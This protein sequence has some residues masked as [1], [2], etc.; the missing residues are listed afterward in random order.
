VTRRPRAATSTASVTWRDG[1]HLT[2]TPIWCDARRRRDVCFVSSA[3]RVGR[4]GH[5]QLIG[6][7]LTLALLGAT[8]GGHLAVPLHRRFTLGTLRL[9]LIDPARGPGASALFVDG[10]GQ[11]F[12][13]AGAIRAGAEVRACDALVVGAPYGKR[14]HAFPPLAQTIERV[15]AWAK[16]EL[17]GGRRPVLLVDTAL[18]GLEVA[19]HL[20][21][22]GIPLAGARPIREAAQRAGQL[23]TSLHLAGGVLPIAA[24]GKEPRAIVWPARDRTAAVNAAKGAPHALATLGAGGDFPWVA[25]AGRTDL[26]AWIESA[27]AREVYVTGACADD[28]A[29]ALGPRA[30]VIGPPHQMT[31][32]EATS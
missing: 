2:G 26:L 11:T 4:T 13:Y 31:L 25:A 18:D 14:E 24:P 29:S 23:A 3:D 6:S 10:A 16:R 30:R 7:P 12:L 9:E 22:A 15:L 28:I 20:A 27:N 32:F 19:M 8:G 5:G 17:A 21:A 1:V